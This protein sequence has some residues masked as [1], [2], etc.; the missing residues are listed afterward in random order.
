MVAFADAVE[1]DGIYYFLSSGDNSAMVTKNPNKYSGSVAIP[2][3]VT[4]E[5]VTFEVKTIKSFSFSQCTDLSSISIPNSVTFIGDKAFYKT[6]GLTAVH[7]SDVAAW[8]N[9]TFE[10]KE[11]NPLYYANHLYLNNEEIK[12]L[13][14]PDSVTSIK[15]YAFFGCSLSSVHISDLV[16]WCNISFENASSNPLNSAQHLYLNDEEI[17][18]LI[19]PDS[20]TNIRDYAFNGCCNLTSITIPNSVRRIGINAFKGC[21]K[22]TSVSIPNSV[23]SICKSAFEGCWDLSFVSIGS[24]VAFIDQYAFAN[25]NSIKHVYCYASDV[26]TTDPDAFYNSGISYIT[27]HV[28]GSSSG[29]YRRKSPWKSFMVIEYI[30]ESNDIANIP[31]QAVLMQFEGG[32]LNVQGLDDGT[33]VSL[34][35][36]EGQLAGTVTSR[37]GV[38]SLGTTLQPGTPAIVRIGSKSVKVVVR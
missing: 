11:S 35:T 34:Y 33:P 38:A 25:C 32:M 22:L 23:Y 29:A 12:D 1:I 21:T 24:G 2:A 8:C 26:P 30:E 9:I 14:I 16:A 31:A 36:V 15:K 27:L 6:T 19:I 20:I 28:L 7:I 5:G 37:N 13:V 17:I 4:Y 18:D 3:T 10:S